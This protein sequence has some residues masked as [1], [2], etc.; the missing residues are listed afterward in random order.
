MAVVEVKIEG[1]IAEVLLNRPAQKNALSEEMFEA[2][3][4]VGDDLK[5]AKGLRVVILSGAAGDF[6]SGLDMAFMGAMAGKQDSLRETLLNPPAGELANWFQKPAFA[7]Q[8]LNVPVIA[9]IA[10]VCLGGG[11][12]I[13]LA[14]DIRIARPDARLSI[15]EAKWGMIP[16]MGISQSLPKLMRADQAKMLMMSAEMISGERGLA[17]GLVTELADDPLARARALAVT[18]T[19]KSPDAIAGIKTLVEEVWTMAPGAGLKREAEIQAP[20]IGGSNQME[21]V[22]A[23]MQKRKP[24]FG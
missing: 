17:E 23:A 22:M 12:Q 8:E 1:G 20:I 7:W 24:N 19:D 18:I 11:L 5:Q 21:A 15:M 13:A 4:A 6:C 10:G 9:A 16:D 14:A 3:A 2:L